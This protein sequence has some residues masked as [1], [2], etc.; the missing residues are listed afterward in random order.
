M[1]DSGP[2][3]RTPYAHF[4][5]AV[6]WVCCMRAC[7]GVRGVR[8]SGSGPGDDDDDDPVPIGDPPDDED[9]DDG[10]EDDDDDDDEEPLQ[11]S[12]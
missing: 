6:A 9:G 7:G 5:D 8:A 2:A 10:D 3:P 11:A 12:C 1:N 4:A